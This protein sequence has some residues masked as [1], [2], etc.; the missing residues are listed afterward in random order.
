M[1]TGGTNEKVS[2]KQKRKNTE[3]IRLNAIFAG[4]PDKRIRTAVAK[5]PK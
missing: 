2:V 1:H 3:S 5:W 4:T